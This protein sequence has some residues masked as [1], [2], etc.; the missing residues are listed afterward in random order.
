MLFLTADA[1][2]RCCKG[3]AT[4]LEE[5]NIF[6]DLTLHDGLKNPHHLEG[7]R[8][9]QKKVYQ[10]KVPDIQQLTYNLSSALNKT[11]SCAAT[12]S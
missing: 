6:Q 3:S 4:D 7:L 5:L 2:K 8:R 11:S 10:L 9:S 1:P 12:Q